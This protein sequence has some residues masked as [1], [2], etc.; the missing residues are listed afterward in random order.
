MA[1]QAFL[2][3]VFCAVPFLLWR[4]RSHLLPSDAGWGFVSVLQLLRVAWR[5]IVV[6][7]LC[8]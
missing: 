8:D 3:L 4:N 1:V 7:L 5:E 2:L 6:S